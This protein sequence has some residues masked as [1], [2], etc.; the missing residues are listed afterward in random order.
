M[1]EK[2]KY[3]SRR[4]GVIFGIILML[5][6]GLF[7]AFNLG[8]FDGGYKRVIFSWPM[9]LVLI[10]VINY[11]HRHSFSGTVFILAGAF[12]LI[13]RLAMINP[14]IFYWV[15]PDFTRDYWGV[16]LIA[17]G[18]LLILQLIF[19]PRKRNG[20]STNN[21]TY[22]HKRAHRHTHSSSLGKLDR[23]SVFAN[24]EE[25][26]LDPE[27]QGGEINAVFGSITLDLRKTSLP[28]GETQLEINAVFGGIDIYIPE[29]WDVELHLSHVFGG[30]TDRRL[31]SGNIDKSRKLIIH[32]GCVF[33]GGEIKN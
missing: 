15:T 20:C 25:I 18:I 3:R 31:Y 2:I 29:N 10:G 1:D 9:L 19:H 8:W 13:P 21:D 22:Y 16:L 27:F 26:V 30:F 5:V 33:G 14:D 24:V 32:G 7:L 6:G 12:F 28:E 23:N 11:F 4:S 17:G